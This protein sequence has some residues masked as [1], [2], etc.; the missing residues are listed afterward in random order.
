MRLIGHVCQGMLAHKRMYSLTWPGAMYV[1]L[2]WI[3]FSWKMSPGAAGLDGDESRDDAISRK[4][5]I[6]PLLPPRVEIN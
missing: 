5:Y 1:L 4:N 3:F 6:T 2:K